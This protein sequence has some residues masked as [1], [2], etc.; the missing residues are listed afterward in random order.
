MAPSA[1][2]ASAVTSSCGAMF[3]GVLSATVTLKVVL[4]ELPAASVAVQVTVVAA[5]REL[6]AGG[7]RAVDG[8]VGVD[9]VG[10][11]GLGVGDRGTA[12]VLGIRGYVGVRGDIRLVVS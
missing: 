10:G 3:G 9:G 12:C 1:S 7:R 11:G 5:K 8:R 4:A 6:G 2:S